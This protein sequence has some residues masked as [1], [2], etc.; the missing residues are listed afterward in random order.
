MTRADLRG[1][2]TMPLTARA[3]ELGRR[4][5]AVRAYRSPA[6]T[7]DITD[8]IHQRPA[9]HE[10]VAGTIAAALRPLADVL[11]TSVRDQPALRV[12]A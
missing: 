3:R 10:E 11:F 8:P 1:L 7:D 6:D 4:L 12:S 9:V 2:R 5:D